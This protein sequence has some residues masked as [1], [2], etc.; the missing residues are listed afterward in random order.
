MCGRY[1]S[2][3]HPGDLVEEFEV[4]QDS[5]AQPTR[6]MERSDLVGAVD[7]TTGE[8]IGGLSTTAR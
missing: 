4:E 3:S 1:A 8:I 5:T 2:S 6:S 7:P